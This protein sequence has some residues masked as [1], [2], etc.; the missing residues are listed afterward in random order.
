VSRSLSIVALAALVVGGCSAQSAPGYV[1]SYQRDQYEGAKLAYGA[2]SSDEVLLMMTCAPGSGHVRLSAVTERTQE[3]IV[4]AS[5]G[6]RDRFSGELAPSEL[7]GLLLETQAKTSARSL[8]GF[9]R[10]GKLSMS[11]SGE[12]VSLAAGPDERAGVTQFFE[13]CRV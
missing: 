6:A 4:L 3:E 8:T 1:W 10:T 9:A 2:P 7:G 12:T 13:V 5:A 11:A